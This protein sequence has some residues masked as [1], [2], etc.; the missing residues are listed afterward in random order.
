MSRYPRTRQR[1][2]VTTAAILAAA[3]ACSDSSLLAPTTASHANNPGGGGGG[4]G[5]GQRRLSSVA[6]NLASSS[7][8]IGGPSV[9]YTV[10]VENKGGSVSNVILQGAI[11]QGS[12]S[13]PAGGAPRRSSSSLK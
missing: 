7:L 5:G 8:S 13:Q 9:S 10:T 12:V 1:W 3:S 11:V 4:G 6:V 2:L